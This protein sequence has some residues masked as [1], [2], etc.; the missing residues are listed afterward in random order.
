MAQTELELPMIP[1]KT[2]HYRALV[3]DAE[4]QGTNLATLVAEFLTKEAEALLEWK[5]TPVSVSSIRVDYV[6][7]KGSQKAIM[8]CRPDLGYKV[9]VLDTDPRSQD[10]WAARMSALVIAARHSESTR[11]FEYTGRGA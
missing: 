7:S 3:N 2:E 8:R 9:E 10:E 5:I 11:I 1:I 4:K 6:L